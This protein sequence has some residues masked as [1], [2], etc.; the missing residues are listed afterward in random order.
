MEKIKIGLETHVK[1]NTLKKLF[2]KCKIYKSKP[3][4]R[5]CP[6]CLGYPG[7][8]P[9]FNLDSLN[10]ILPFL[11]SLKGQLANKIIFDRKLYNYYDLP[12]NFQITQEQLPINQ[13]IPI[14]IN[15]KII[16]IEKILIEEDAGK[17]IHQKDT[18][19]IDYNRSGEMLLE[20]TT[21]PDF[22]NIKD[23]C[24]YIL[25]LRSLI[26]YFNISNLDN[27][28]GDFRND[29]NISILYNNIQF[30]RME[31]KNINK[32]SIIKKVIKYE[33]HRQKQMIVNQKNKIP[34]ISETR[35]WNEE[36]NKTFLMRNKQK[37]FFMR[38]FNIPI[39]NIDNKINNN[40]N[41]NILNIDLFF[42]LFNLCILL[43][44]DISLITYT[45]SNK[46]LYN[47]I[48]LILKN[49]NMCTNKKFNN[50][51]IFFHIFLIQRIIKKDNIKIFI[52]KIF[53]KT[54][55]LF[56]KC[57]ILSHILGFNHLAQYINKHINENNLKEQIIYLEKTCNKQSN[58]NIIKN[59]IL[60][61]KKIL[62]YIKLK[63]KFNFILGETIKFL[64]IEN[65]IFNIQNIIKI[66][67]NL[68]QTLK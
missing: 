33:I 68:I 53:L 56:S 15:N 36:I 21:K 41:N 6:I 30:P 7:T 16:N 22:N 54:Y 27:N 59:L 24:Y 46:T 8:L 63:S 25:L 31:I 26:R 5:I 50:L 4:K 19:Y 44:I 42:K 48:L 13:N 43:N 14:I 60:K 20:I 12:K 37:Y 17:T 49:N 38:E 18:C 66:L 65:K 10:K 62:S 67:Q 23:V 11:I 9:L 28:N 61:N 35:G 47:F 58:S 32:I 1:I 64:K 39:I 52:I 29:L 57:Y 55:I 45:F 40:N 3:N 34:K 2:C 51:I